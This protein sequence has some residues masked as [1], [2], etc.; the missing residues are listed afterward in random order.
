MALRQSALHQKI[1]DLSER[2]SRNLLEFLFQQVLIPEVQLRLT[3][4]PRSLAMW[5]NETTQHYGV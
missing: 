2:E 4:K 1:V 3:W 5:H